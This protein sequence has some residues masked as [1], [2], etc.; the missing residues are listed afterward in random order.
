[1]SCGDT[2][3]LNSTCVKSFS[4]ACILLNNTNSC[5]CSAIYPRFC[6]G[7]FCNIVGRRVC[8]RREDVN[9]VHRHIPVQTC[10]NQQGIIS[11]DW[12]AA[13]LVVAIY[14][15]PTCSF[16]AAADGRRLCRLLPT[17]HQQASVQNERGREKNIFKT[18]I[19]VGG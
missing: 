2:W 14:Y 18:T 13:D 7:I 1:M 16:C 19:N 10:Y 4:N 3:Y 8:Q 15:Y 12:W 9:Q 11:G 5:V 17:R 6:E